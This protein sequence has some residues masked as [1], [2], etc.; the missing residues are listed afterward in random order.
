[1]SRPGLCVNLRGF[2]V[3][4]EKATNEGMQSEIEQL[5]CELIEYVRKEKAFKR[6]MKQVENGHMRRTISLMRIIDAL[7]DEIK[8][9]RADDKDRLQHVADD[10]GERVKEL[11]T[12]YDISRLRSGPNF[13]MDHILQAVVD[14]IPAAIPYPENAG[15]RIRF[16]H[17]AFT[18]RNFK[19][20]PWKL[21]KKITVN[22]EEIGDLE[23]C[24]REMIPNLDEEPFL[25]ETE[26]L[27]TAIAESIA[28]IVEREWAEI[29][30]RGN[31]EKIEAM[32]NAKPA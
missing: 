24:Y 9:I 16:E 13:S 22:H 15:V 17:Y 8:S 11:N 10:L 12:L 5:K 21:S 3:M 1:M 32:R 30:I 26:K 31:L 6:Q 27:V 14:F 18:T 2:T 28:Q 7:R 19:D 25:I 4:A 29:E 20:T 23:I